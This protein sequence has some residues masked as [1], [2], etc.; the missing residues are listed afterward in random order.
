VLAFVLVGAA[1][2]RQN[3]TV[4]SPQL[5]PTP[6]AP[7]P[8]ASD[9]LEGPHVVL[10]PSGRPSVAVRV[11][12]AMTAAQ[13]T[14]GL[15]FRR[16]LEP[17][18]GMLFLFP[19]ER[20]QVFWMHNTYLALD[21]IFLRANGEVLGVVENAT[22]MTDDPREVPGDSKYVLE[23]N[24]GFARR[25]GVGPGTRFDLVNVPSGGVEPDEG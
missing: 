21:M 11:E 22:P 6:A 25:H 5:E 19:A 17:L 10:R 13:R 8:A 9:R 7:V 12:L 14:R 1:C 20:H 15:M 4:T 3:S 24:A 16:Q 2:G 23:V 18:A